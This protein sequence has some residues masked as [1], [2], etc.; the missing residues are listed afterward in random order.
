MEVVVSCVECTMSAYVNVN[1]LVL[2][3][4]YVRMSRH[5]EDVIT[6]F[7]PKVVISVVI[8]WNMRCIGRVSGRC[9]YNFIDAF[10]QWQLFQVCAR[11]IRFCLD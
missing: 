1:D 9:K 4:P 7:I 8:Y 11:D 6:D 5:A 2:Y 10:L 3:Q